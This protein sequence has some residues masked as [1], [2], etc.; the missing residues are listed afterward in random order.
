MLDK[1]ASRI[2]CMVFWL[3]RDASL[4]NVKTEMRHKRLLSIRLEPINLIRINFPTYHVMLR[5]CFP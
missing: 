2:V 3:D 1:V 5:C 4:A